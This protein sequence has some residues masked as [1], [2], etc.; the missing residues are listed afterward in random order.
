MIGRAMQLYSKQWGNRGRRMPRAS[1]QVRVPDQFALGLIMRVCLHLLGGKA[2][3]KTCNRNLGPL[4]TCTHI[5]MGTHTH[6]CVHTPHIHINTHTCMELKQCQVSHRG[7]KGRT[8]NK[9]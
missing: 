7:W 4:H 8:R 9:V 2:T 3:K 1:W 6:R 5:C